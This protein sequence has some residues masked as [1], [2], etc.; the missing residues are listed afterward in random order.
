M[1]SARPR[2]IFVP[3]PLFFAGRFFLL[4]EQPKG[5]TIMTSQSFLRSCLAV[6]L[7]LVMAGCGYTTQTSSGS[8]YLRSYAEQADLGSVEEIDEEIRMAANVEPTLQFPAKVGIARID[9]GELSLIPETEARAWSELA[10]RLGPDWGQFVPINP[11]IVALASKPRDDDRSYWGCDYGG[12]C[13]EFVKRTV[14]DIRLG[15]A[16]QHVDA[17]LIYEAS[18]KSES[19]SNPLAV[20]KLVLV[21]FFLAPSESVSADGFAQAMLVDV[22]NGY[23][24]GFAS[25]EAEDGGYGLS[26][27]VN[28]EESERSTIV[29]AKTAAVVNLT[30]EVETMARDLRRELTE[31]RAIAAETARLE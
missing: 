8:A 4:G 26:T 22:R 24:Y 10:D 20:T 3:V 6:V 19:Y 25:A 11:L 14:R 30:A 23:T 2:R 1:K 27:S 31:T 21:G 18:A 16:R 15:A 29:D 13:Q 17:V 12:K 9:T 28:W 7:T 5:G